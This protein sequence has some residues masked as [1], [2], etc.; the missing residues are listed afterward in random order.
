MQKSRKAARTVKTVRVVSRKVR[1]EVTPSKTTTTRTFKRTTRTTVRFVGGRPNGVILYRGPSL[2]DRSPIVCIA[3]GLRDTSKNGK[4]GDMV[5]TYI[6]ADG[7]L[8]PIVAMAKGKDA[9]VCGDC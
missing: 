9:A 4:T 2:L 6:L 7:R 5:G 1:T 3:V 8:D